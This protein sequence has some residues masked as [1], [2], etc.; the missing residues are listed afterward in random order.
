[1]MKVEKDYDIKNFDTRIIISSGRLD[2][3]RGRRYIE[4][5][6][7]QHLGIDDEVAIDNLVKLLET[8]IEE[9][10]ASED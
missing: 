5:Y 8:V 4:F 1:M 7:E 3:A 2:S 6:A 10:N 9:C